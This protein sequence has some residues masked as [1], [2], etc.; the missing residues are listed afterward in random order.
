[1]SFYLTPSLRVQR[2]NPSCSKNGLPRFARNDAEFTFNPTKLLQDL[3]CD[4][5]L[6]F[7]QNLNNKNELL[8]NPVIAS[9]AWQSILQQN[10]IAALRSQ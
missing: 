10:W 3:V 4:C 2:S 5:V 1:M 7:M 8:F 6:K 9:A